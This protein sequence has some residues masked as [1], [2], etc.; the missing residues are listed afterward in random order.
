MEKKLK[1]FGMQNLILEAEL[2]KIE[3]SGIE[4]GHTQYVEKNQIVDAELFELEIRKKAKKMSDLY[5]L[6]FCLENS[7]RSLIT[8][9]LS[10]KHGLNW[11]EVKT[12]S[13][14]K[15]AVEEL[16]KKEKDT[17]MSLRSDNPLDYTNFGDL[18]KIIDHNW[19]DFSDTLRSRKS[20]K[21]ILFR[22]NLLRNPIA[23]SAELD[24]DEIM[25]FKLHIKDWLRIQ[26]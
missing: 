1:I 7:I 13:D 11:W 23:H 16:Q 25:R 21:D 17:T 2:A 26:M 3:N 4:I 12:P 8:G 20:M 24:D 10:E 6:Y 5:Y 19:D 18:I 14:V 15:I 9:V 22:L